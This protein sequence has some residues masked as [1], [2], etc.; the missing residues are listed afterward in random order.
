MHSHISYTYCSPPTA[1][2]NVTTTT[3]KSATNGLVII[4]G[5]PGD[6]TYAV[7]ETKAPAGY[8]LLMGTKDVTPVVKTAY[9]QTVTMYLDAEGKV[10]DTETEETKVVTTDT[11][12]TGVTI[13][14]ETGS[15]LPSTGGI[16]T[17]I[18]YVVGSL[19]I[20]GAG[21]VL[22]ARTRMDKVSR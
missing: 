1:I 16:G 20:I 7:K 12:V 10:T 9:T 22:V 19:L 3:V 8:N 17:T 15:T 11:N 13:V 6:V 18:F 21:I 4:K 2:E 5:V 14:N